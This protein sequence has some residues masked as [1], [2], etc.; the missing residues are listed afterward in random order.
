[1]LPCLTM[2]EEEIRSLATLARLQLTD[3][4]VRTLGKDMEGILAHMEALAEVNTDGV[5]P[6]SHVLGGV[7]HLRAD[8]V[9]PSLP[10]QGPFDVPAI[11]TSGK[12]P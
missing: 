6:M 12:K 10:E 7:G 8:R 1:M 5:L 3:E 9:C 2:T 11:L 4:E